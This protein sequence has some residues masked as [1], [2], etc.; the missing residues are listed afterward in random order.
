[1]NGFKPR[2]GRSGSAKRN[3]RIGYYKHSR[4]GVRL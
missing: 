1:M 4:G 2:H 3:K